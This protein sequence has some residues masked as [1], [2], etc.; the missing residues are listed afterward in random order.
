MCVKEEK[1]FFKTCSILQNR[2]N[3]V[4]IVFFPLAIINAQQLG[5]VEMISQ[6]FIHQKRN[7]TTTKMIKKIYSKQKKKTKS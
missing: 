6:I 5:C 7:Y 3:M 2:R 1:T 4:S